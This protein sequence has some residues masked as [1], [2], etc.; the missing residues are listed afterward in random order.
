MRALLS[1]LLFAVVGASVGALISYLYFWGFL[2]YDMWLLYVIEAAIGSA[3]VGIAAYAVA[4]LL[5]R[6][7]RAA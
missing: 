5:R 3:V 6:R 4:S 1:V 2:G 7:R